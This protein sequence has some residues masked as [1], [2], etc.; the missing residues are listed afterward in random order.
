M[1]I[2]HTH[3]VCGNDSYSITAKMEKVKQQIPFKKQQIHIHF[4]FRSRSS[5]PV[6]HRPPAPSRSS[7]N[8]SLS[9]CSNHQSLILLPCCYYAMDSPFEMSVLCATVVNFFCASP[10]SELHF[11]RVCDGTF[12]L[13]FINSLLLYLN[14]KLYSMISFLLWRIHLNSILL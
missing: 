10:S 8:R 14:H 13:N 12:Q 5:L 2:I 6:V 1:I 7:F 11:L 4:S 3:S 9:F